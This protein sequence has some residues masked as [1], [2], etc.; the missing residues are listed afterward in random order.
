MLL[1][2]RCN[3]AVFVLQC[4]PVDLGGVGCQ[5]NLNS[6]QQATQE[7]ASALSQSMHGEQQHLIAG[8][9]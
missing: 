2:E 6:L 3:L 7:A 8:R 5:H 4:A 9:T 1:Q